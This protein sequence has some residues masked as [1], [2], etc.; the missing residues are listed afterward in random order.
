MQKGVEIYFKICYIII[1]HWDVWV[2]RSL[3]AHLNGVQE[4]GGSNPLTQTSTKPRKDA[5]LRRLFIF[6]F[7][8]FNRL[9]KH[10]ANMSYFWPKTSSIF[11]AASFCILGI[12]CEYVSRVI[13]IDEC[14]SLSCTI[15]G[16]TCYG[17]FVCSQPPIVG[18]NW[19]DFV[20]LRDS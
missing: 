20:T 1:R 3:V 12:R 10:F 6:Y 9:C 15:L 11:S 13:D 14:P 17:F 4:V 7:V 18:K 19:C 16:C 8:C 5:D 2:W